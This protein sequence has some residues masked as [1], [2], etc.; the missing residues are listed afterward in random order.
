MSWASSWSRLGGIDVLRREAGE[1]KTGGDGLQNEFIHGCLRSSAFTRTIIESQRG[2]GALLVR[3][4]VPASRAHV[5]TRA[6][7]SALNGGQHPNKRV[8][9]KYQTK[10]F[11]LLTPGAL[12]ERQGDAALSPSPASRGLQLENEV[13][14]GPTKYS[15]VRSAQ[16]HPGNVSGS[17]FPGPILPFI[18]AKIF[19][20]VQLSPKNFGV[21]CFVWSKVCRI[22]EA[23]QPDDHPPCRPPAKAALGDLPNLRRRS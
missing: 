7:S 14:K 21:G 22:R 13:G 16:P 17:S 15:G 11:P 9:P 12:E 5:T 8:N 2:S 3:P 4:L 18:T 10:A 1:E 23:I 6:P 19:L 20:A